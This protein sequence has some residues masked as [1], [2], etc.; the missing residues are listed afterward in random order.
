M[1][2]PQV[3]KIQFDKVMGY[4]EKGKAE[5][6]K[7]ALGGSR[8]GDVGYFVEPTVFTDVT[9]DMTIFKEEIF[10]PVMSM[11]RFSTLEEAVERANHTHYG[12]GAGIITENVGKAHKVA[13]QLRAGTVYVNCYDV[14]DVA[15]PFGGFGES[16]H[17][18][19]LGQYG[20]ENYTEVKSVIIESPGAG[21]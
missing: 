11:A 14:F 2:G 21:R 16:G 4:I 10:G 5:G 15:A 17:G 7:L 19:E 9:D 12:L 3:D 6:A 18:R 1:Q 20:L 8:H 13:S